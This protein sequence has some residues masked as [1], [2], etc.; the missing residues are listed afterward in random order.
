MAITGKNQFGS[1]PLWGGVLIACIILTLNYRVEGMA[2]VHVKTGD[3][4]TVSA[5]LKTD[6]CSVEGTK[7]YTLATPPI[8]GVC[9]CSHTGLTFCNVT[10]GNE[11]SYD[12]KRRVDNGPEQVD[13]WFLIVTK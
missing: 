7:N 6:V 1:I 9:N 11:G 2:N 10:Q 13:T 4:K 12:L 3:D 8:H 5:N